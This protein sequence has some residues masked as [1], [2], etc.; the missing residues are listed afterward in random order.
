MG[1]IVR[2]L[3]HEVTRLKDENQ[4]LRDEAALLRGYVSAIES[5]M[6]AVDELDRRPRFSAAGPYPVQR[7]DRHHLEGWIADGGRRRKRRAGLRV[8]AGRRQHREAGRAAAAHRQGDRRWV[9]QNAKPAI[10]ENARADPRFY[11]GIDD[12]Y[13]FT[14][15]SVLA[16]PIVGHGQVLGVIEVLNKNNGKSYGQATCSCCRCCAASPG[17]CSTRWPS[18]KNRNPPEPLRASPISTGH[19]SACVPFLY[20]APFPSPDAFLMT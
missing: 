13:K 3:Q 11:N 4:A 10:V 19:R 7:H 18:R 5:L 2:N 6:D 14:T 15:N 12:A 8:R 20:P 9:A 17:R 16:A 1:D